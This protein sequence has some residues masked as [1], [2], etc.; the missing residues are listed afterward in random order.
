MPVVMSLACTQM[1]MTP[2]EAITAATLNAAWSLD[3]GGQV[4]S[5]EAGKLADFVVHEAGD[6]RE[7]PYFLGTQRPAMV[8]AQGSRYSN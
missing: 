6:Y 4:G 3:L 1:K 8:F 7:I 2:A 5:L